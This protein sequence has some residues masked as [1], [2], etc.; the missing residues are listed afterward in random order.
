MA[1]GS[2]QRR[3]RD[4]V[5]RLKREANERFFLAS[6]GSRHFDFDALGRTPADAVN[7][8]IQGLRSHAGQ[9]EIAP[10]WW[11]DDAMKAAADDGKPRAHVEEPQR[12]IDDG[13]IQVRELELG[14]AYRDGS[15][16]PVARES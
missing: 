6:L 3:A 9:Y 8:L 1:M 4:Y 12:L 13:L 5:L 11:Y 14:Q 15:V 2:S 7:T 16:L 10:D